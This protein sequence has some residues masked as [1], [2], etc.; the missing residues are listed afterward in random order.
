MEITPI[1]SKNKL[2]RMQLFLARNELN[3]VAICS[4]LY[5]FGDLAINNYQIWCIFDKLDEKIPLLRTCSIKLYE[6]YPSTVIRGL[7]MNSSNC[8]QFDKKNTTK[9]S[10]WLMPDSLHIRHVSNLEIGVKFCLLLFSFFFQLLFYQ[11]LF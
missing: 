10:V 2:N 4:N 3:R 1:K 11:S 9:F 5:K 7:Y 6:A 8:I